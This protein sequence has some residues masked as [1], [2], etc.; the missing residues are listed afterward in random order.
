MSHRE[1]YFLIGGLAIG[2]GCD[3]SFSIVFV[4]LGIPCWFFVPYLSMKRE[5]MPPTKPAMAM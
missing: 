5:T 3:N 4:V 1:L 2:F